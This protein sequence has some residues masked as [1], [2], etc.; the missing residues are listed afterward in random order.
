MAYE[1]SSYITKPDNLV[2]KNTRKI[3]SSLHS[4]ITAEV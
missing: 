2:M 3:I 1:Q 4:F